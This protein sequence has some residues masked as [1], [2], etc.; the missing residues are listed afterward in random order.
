MAKRYHGKDHSMSGPEYYGG[1]D[2]RRAQERA[3]SSMMPNGQG[4]FANLPQEVVMKEYPRVM[5]ADYGLDDTIKTI[6]NQMRDD[7]KDKKK[8]AYP[9]KY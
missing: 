4:S 9:E 7:M 6:D 8:G 2:E 1:P 5:Y 3:D